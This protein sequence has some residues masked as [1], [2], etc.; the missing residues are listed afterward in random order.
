M[1]TAVAVPAI[2]L[3][4]QILLFPIFLFHSVFNRWDNVQRH[5]GGQSAL[6]YLLNQVL[7]SYRKIRHTQNN[8][9]SNFGVACNPAK[10]THKVNQCTSQLY[11]IFHS[12]LQISPNPYPCLDNNTFHKQIH[13]AYRINNVIFYP[14]FNSLCI[15]ILIFYAT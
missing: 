10:L 4:E 11:G 2:H 1:K 6:F 7:I 3:R 9:H 15:F 13:Q 5:S 8:V 12:S 14:S